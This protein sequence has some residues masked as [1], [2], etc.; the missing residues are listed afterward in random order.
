MATPTHCIEIEARVNN[1]WSEK[2]IGDYC[3]GKLC[4]KVDS[5]IYYNFENL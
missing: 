5:I 2:E 4:F 3:T 1:G